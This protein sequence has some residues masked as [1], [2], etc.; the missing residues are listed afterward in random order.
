METT[1]QEDEQTP[2]FFAELSLSQ[3]LPLSTCHL[4]FEV[5]DGSLVKSDLAPTLQGTTGE[6]EE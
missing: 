6:E 2:L 3:W 5:L 1:R 4:E